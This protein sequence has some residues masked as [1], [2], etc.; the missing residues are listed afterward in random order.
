MLDI[1]LSLMEKKK[2]TGYQLALLSGQQHGTIYR[3]LNGKNPLGFKLFEKLVNSMGFD[4]D[5]QTKE[6]FND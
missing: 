1:L 5:I 2:I 4:V 6:R 3:I